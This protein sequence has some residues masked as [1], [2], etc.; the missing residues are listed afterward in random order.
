MVGIAFYKEDSDILHV[1]A[2]FAELAK[3]S[4]DGLAE[5]KLESLFDEETLLEYQVNMAS[6]LKITTINRRC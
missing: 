2:R 1:N 5:E 6:E 3:R 4:I